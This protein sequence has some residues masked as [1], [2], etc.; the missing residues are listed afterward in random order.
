MRGDIAAALLFYPSQ[1]RF[2]ELGPKAPVHPLD[3]LWQLTCPTLFLFGDA[4]YA[5]PPQRLAELRERI[6]AWGV[7]ADIR[8]YAGASHAFSAPSGPFRHDEAKHAA[9]DDAVAF[10]RTHTRM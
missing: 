4:D 10:L 1:A 3:L 7:N 5:M 9:W 6:D 8:L 2:H